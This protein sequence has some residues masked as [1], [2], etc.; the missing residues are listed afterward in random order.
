VRDWWR[1]AR[2]TVVTLTWEARFWAVIGITGVL[3]RGLANSIPVL[4]FMSAWAC[5]RTASLGK[6][7]AKREMLEEEAGQGD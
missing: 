7:E 1:S 2:S 6:T 5:F 3:W 4:F